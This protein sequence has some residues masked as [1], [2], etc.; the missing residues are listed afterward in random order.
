MKVIRFKIGTVQSISGVNT[1]RIAVTESK[2]HPK[3]KKRYKHTKRFLAHFTGEAPTIG[4]QVT[5]IE[6]RP[7]SARKRWRIQTTKA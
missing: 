2:S 6:A 5:I 1:A 7:L 3:Y 4:K